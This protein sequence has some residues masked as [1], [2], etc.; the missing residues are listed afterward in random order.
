[1]NM[2]W[3][4]FWVVNLITPTVLIVDTYLHGNKHTALIF[5]AILYPFALIILALRMTIGSA[6]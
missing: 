4:V 5:A 2:T 6:T 3:F 1:M